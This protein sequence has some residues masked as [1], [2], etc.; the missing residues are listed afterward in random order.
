[1]DNSIHDAWSFLFITSPHCSGFSA[2]VIKHLDPTEKICVTLSARS[3]TVFLSP[4]LMQ[5]WQPIW[6]EFSAKK[7][8]DAAKDLILEGGVEAI[9]LALQSIQYLG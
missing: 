1:L 7:G 2:I 3:G 5:F 4:V 8:D 6:G 9:N